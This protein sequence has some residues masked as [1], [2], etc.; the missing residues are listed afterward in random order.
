[1]LH[2]IRSDYAQI[3]TVAFLLVNGPGKWSLDALLQREEKLSPAKL[4]HAA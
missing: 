1:V 3:L 2:E 4:V